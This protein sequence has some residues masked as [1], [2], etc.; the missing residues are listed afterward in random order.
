[1]I[2]RNLLNIISNHFWL[3]SLGF[4]SSYEI[5]LTLKAEFLTYHVGYVVTIVVASTMGFT[6]AMGVAGSSSD[7]Y[8][9][10]ANMYVKV[11]INFGL[12]GNY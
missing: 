6:L 7:Q 1:M 3:K 10:I 9:K 2:S 12:I 5:T 8:A 11:W 4:G